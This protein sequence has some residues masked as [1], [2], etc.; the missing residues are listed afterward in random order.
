MTA[1]RTAHAA[2]DAHAP[3]AAEKLIE[4][5]LRDLLARGDFG[6]LHGPLPVS[7]RLA[8]VDPGVGSPRRAVGIGTHRGDFLVGPD[9]GL[10][11]PAAERLGGIAA[12]V[13]L[14]VPEHASRTFHGRDVFAPAAASLASGTP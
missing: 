8:V 3:Q 14:A 11:V 1:V 13:E 4:I 5:R 9:N 12:A 2:D 6:T 10:L 7:V